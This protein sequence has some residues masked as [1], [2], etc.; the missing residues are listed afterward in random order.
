VGLGGGREVCHGE[1]H[2]VINGLRGM[3]DVQHKENNLERLMQEVCIQKYVTNVLDGDMKHVVCKHA[4]QDYL[5]H[6]LEDVRFTIS[7]AL[8]KEEL[9]VTANIT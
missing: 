6:Y 7:K 9:S 8:Y 1:P 2:S 4:I 5:L 3:A